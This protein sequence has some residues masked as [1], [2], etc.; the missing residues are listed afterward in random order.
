MEI[1]KR[2]KLAREACDLSQAELA[3]HIGWEH[4][5]RI[6][7][8]ERGEREPKSADLKKMSVVLGCSTAWLATGEGP[9]PFDEVYENAAPYQ[10]ANR[11]EKTKLVPLISWVQAGDLCEAAD[12][13]QPGDG[14]DW[15]NCPFKHSD[16]AFC[17]EVKGLSMWPDYREGEIICV[18]PMI[19]A[20]H[21]DD[22]IARTPDG[23]VTFKKLQI[24]GEGM[25]LMA[26]N[27]DWPNRVV[28][29][30][31]DTHIC[32]VVIGSWTAR[33]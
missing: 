1:G 26:V 28:V 16:S 5:S 20:L 25:H 19:E 2:I 14:S 7:A 3:H 9:S 30:P 31:E 13:Y 4:Q 15:L 8:Y 18:D 22:V 6:S 27:P 23:K 12:P 11:Y 24:T 17:L 10:T 33:R 21:G 29:V 32:G